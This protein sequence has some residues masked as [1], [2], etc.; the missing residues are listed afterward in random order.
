MSMCAFGY[1]GISFLSERIFDQISTGDKYWEMIITV[2]SELPG[3]FIAMITVDRYGRRLTMIVYF[4]AFGICM[5]LLVDDNVRNNAFAST[6]LVFCGRM[7]ISMAY[8]II[9]IYFSEYF[10]T[11]VRNT[12]LG[13]AHGVSSIS[14]IAATYL[15]QSDNIGYAS[16]L[17]GISGLVASV[18][19][20]AL[21]HDTQD[22]DMSEVIDDRD[23]KEDCKSKTIDGGFLF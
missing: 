6:V 21:F 7:C 8:I 4:A 22:T 12:S 1:F 16:Y 19:C 18:C 20:F 13:M 11:R 3:I 23:A 2:F 10:P 15:S 14:T 9:I 17:Y 5:L